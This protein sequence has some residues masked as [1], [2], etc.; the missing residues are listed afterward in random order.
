MLAFWLG[1]KSAD[2]IDYEKANMKQSKLN[3]HEKPIFIQTLCHHRS[4]ELTVVYKTVTLMFVRTRVM[5]RF[6]HLFSD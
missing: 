3:W 4:S 5:K 2:L 6:V 1:S